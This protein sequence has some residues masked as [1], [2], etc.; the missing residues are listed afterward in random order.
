[1][2]AQQGAPGVPGGA[3]PGVAGTPRQGAQPGQPRGGQAPPG[4]IHRDQ[5]Q[6]PR[7]MPRKVG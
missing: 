4:A 3:G 2:Q 6:D 5:M 7:V 1:M